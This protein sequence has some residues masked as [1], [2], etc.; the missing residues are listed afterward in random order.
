MT[1][2]VARSWMTRTAAAVVAVLLVAGCSA[3]GVSTVTS[4][5]TVDA[6]LQAA[7][8]AAGITP[9]PAGP[10]TEPVEG[11]LPDVAL[12][13]LDTGS[14]VSLAGL[15]TGK[16]RV[17]NLWA[18]WCG[19]CRTEAPV[20]AAVSSQMV[21]KVDFLGIDVSDPQP[22]MAIEFAKAAHWTYPQLADPEGLSKQ[23]PISAP[24]LPATVFVDAG[25]RI[26]ARH[27]GVLE[28]ETELQGL[29]TKHFGVQP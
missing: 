21:G 22:A 4:S 5:P 26:V 20:L 28:T 15:A 14:Q 6:E 8:K 18:Q 1:T 11:G 3:G 7:Y 29:I 13:C 12:S 24:G 2:L 25:G 9:C 10:A 16:P 19:P 23:A 17:I 27:F